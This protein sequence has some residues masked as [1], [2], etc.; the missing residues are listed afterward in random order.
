MQSCLPPEL[1]FSGSSGIILANEIP[2]PDQNNID[3]SKDS[4]SSSD[5]T[6]NSSA[7]NKKEGKFFFK[8]ISNH[9]YGRADLA[10]Q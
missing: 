7:S 10:Q 9:I 2:N 8:K 5:N 4:L 6:S 1:S 3:N